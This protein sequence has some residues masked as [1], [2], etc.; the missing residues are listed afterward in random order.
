LGAGNPGLT[1][2]VW[3]IIEPLAISSVATNATLAG[4][5]TGASPLS[6]AGW[7]VSFFTIGQGFDNLA[8]TANTLSLFGF[9]LP[10]ALSFGHIVFTVNTVDGTN[11]S[12]V[13]IYT[14]AG[15][16][17][18]N[19]GAQTLGSAGLLAL[20][21]VQGSQTVLPG[22]YLFAFTSAG[23]TLKIVYSNFP[24]QWYYNGSIDTSSAGALPASI[25]AP[26]ITVQARSA[27]FS[28]Y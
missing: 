25:T 6:V 13:G 4:N 8:A 2:S 10:D 9:A 23:S 20:P 18:A 27:Y 15:A 12:D 24:N 17:V 3:G 21:T 26:T 7:P 5:G 28:L 19:I 22:L 16:L 11:N 1:S 14:G